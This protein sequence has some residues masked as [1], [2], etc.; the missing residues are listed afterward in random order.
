[1]LATSTVM[2]RQLFLIQYFISELTNGSIG[3][4]ASSRSYFFLYE[5][6]GFQSS[7]ELVLL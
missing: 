5:K 1:M 4:N 2:H 3:P 7:T 6:L